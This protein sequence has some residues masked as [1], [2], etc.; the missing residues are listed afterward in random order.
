M[1][2]TLFSY[3][4]AHDPIDDP[5]RQLEELLPTPN[6]IRTASGRPGKAY[7]QQEADYT[8]E[9]I[10]DDQNQMIIGSETIQYTNNSPDDL[11]YLWLQL[12]QNIFAQSS[13]R[14]LKRSAPHMSKNDTSS[15]YYAELIEYRRD[16]DGSIS[17]SNVLD[18][19]GQP[20]KHRIQKT[21]MRIDLEDPLASGETVSFSL[22]WSYTINDADLLSMRTG[23]EY[24]EED[25]NYLYEI[26]MFFPR[27][28]PYTDVHGWHHKQYLGSGEFS[29][30]FGDYDVKITVPAD[31]I[32]GA[33][34]ELQNTKE[35]LT[36]KQLKRFEE[37][38]TAERP[39]FVVTPEEAKQAEKQK[40]EQS[41][42]WHFKAENVR[43]FAFA[44]SR[45]FI[46][47]AWGRDID[48]KTVMAMSFY[49][50][51]AEPL[52]S[53]YST[54]AVAHTL[55]VYSE[56][57]LPYPYPVA[58]S[59]NGPIGGMEY[60]MI[61]FN[62]PRPYD[63]GTYAGAPGNGMPWSHSKYALISVIIHEVGHNW[64]PMI[65]NSDER[66]WT[67]MDEGLNSYVQ[68]HAE[69]TWEED[70]PSRRG[71]ADD[72][73]RYMNSSYS[74]PIMTNGDSLLQKGSNA[75][76]KPA[77]A[78]NIL[79]NTVLTPEVFDEAFRDYSQSWAFKR[80]MPAD[81]F[82]LIEDS[83]GEDLDWFWQ[84]WFYST[85]ALDLRINEVR[86]LHPYSSDP[87]V[88]KPLK[89]LEK[90]KKP[91]PKARHEYL[92]G[93]KYIQRYP[94]LYDFYNDY[95][96]LDVTPKDMEQ[97]DDFLEELSEKE[98][99]LL[100]SHQDLYFTVVEIENLGE[101]ISPVI[102]ATTLKDGTIEE[103]RFPADI[104]RRQNK[105][106]SKL[107]VTEQ[108]IV[109]IELDPHIEL[110]DQN[111]D[112]NIYPPEPKKIHYSLEQSKDPPRNPMQK[113]Q[114]EDEDDEDEN[115]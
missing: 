11:S 110:A 55:D 64:F 15:F 49:P 76:G 61:C 23:Y 70:Y 25:D 115:P 35:V 56:M 107:F 74:V 62:G 3:V 4:F 68:Y 65:I 19:E 38:K 53:T 108:P 93:D 42:T 22:D 72:M 12:D 71:E 113:A 21:M 79:R 81:F 6:A 69:Q 67:W 52:W 114:A 103:H 99:S 104:W 73:L 31:H 37:S 54:H 20:L 34:G 112:N 102:A 88:D 63:D 94:E 41:K 45:K 5:F 106:F 51:E 82:R 27:M 13:D 98:R 48:G 2:I 97:Y 58:I 91:I 33:T 89:K 86:T 78:L 101:L 26:A 111:H 80:P 46:W 9:I 75:Y 90:D 92:E 59:V 30:E 57:V 7:W 44:S 8:M 60:P 50:N 16:F 18:Q 100:D 96:P 95:D 77:T 109:K 87:K 14:E 40:S 29:L 85:A 28:A 1:L 83:A 47:D 66:S 84:S 17:I 39:M 105:V 36:K 24:F 32:V 10:L 43:D